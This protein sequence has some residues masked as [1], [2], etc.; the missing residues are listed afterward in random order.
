MKWHKS[1]KSIFSI[2]LES[3]MMKNLW[4]KAFKSIKYST[5]TQNKSKSWT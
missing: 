2:P 4:T 1:K 3:L 5:A